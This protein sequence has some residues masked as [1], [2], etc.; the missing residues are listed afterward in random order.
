MPSYQYRDYHYKDKTFSWLS[1]LYNGNPYIGKTVLILKWG[2]FS[3]YIIPAP[4]NI[5]H[6]HRDPHQ[7]KDDVLIT[8]WIEDGFMTIL[9]PQWNF[10]YWWGG[11]FTLNSPKFCTS[12]DYHHLS[13]SPNHHI[14]KLVCWY[15]FVLPNKDYT[16]SLTRWTLTDLNEVLDHSVIF[17]LILV[18][19]SECISCEIA[20]RQ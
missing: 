7:Y 20:T 6:V 10:L 16:L 5:E 19:D 18:I 9:Y 11:I 12:W 4:L 3:S 13:L 2:R 8:M 1:Y 15:G 14:S 17:K